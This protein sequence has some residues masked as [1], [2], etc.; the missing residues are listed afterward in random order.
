MSVIVLGG[1]GRILRR[2][3]NGEENPGENPVLLAGA[4][5]DNHR[6][7]SELQTMAKRGVTRAVAEV[8]VATVRT[9][10]AGAGTVVAGRVRSGAV[11]TRHKQFIVI[12]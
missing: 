10:P 5:V 7:V 6:S 11:D 9:M 12:L 3:K 2:N 1:S 4:L 8:R